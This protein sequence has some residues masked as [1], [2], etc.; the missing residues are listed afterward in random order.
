M[1]QTEINGEK[2]ESYQH[3]EIFS[4]PQ[5]SERGFLL[6][7]GKW[8]CARFRDF[9]SNVRIRRPDAERVLAIGQ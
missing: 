5:K 4:L 3:V 7:T 1:K 6:R 2:D 8:N 9:K